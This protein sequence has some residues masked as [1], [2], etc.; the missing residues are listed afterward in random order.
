MNPEYAQRSFLGL[1]QGRP[2]AWAR[3]TSR[4][5]SRIGRSPRMILAALLLIPS[6]LRPS[7]IETGTEM[8]PTICARRPPW[9]TRNEPSLM[10]APSA[11]VPGRTS[12]ARHHGHRDCWKGRPGGCRW[13]ASAGLRRAGFPRRVRRLWAGRCRTS[14]VRRCR[15]AARGC[16]APSRDGRRNTR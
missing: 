13:A 2:D 12:P 14:P 16:R 1:A 11:A 7:L 3:S 4:M 10:V 6:P 8:P 9:P 5:A 15:A